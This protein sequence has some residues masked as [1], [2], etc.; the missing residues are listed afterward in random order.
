MRWFYVYIYFCDDDDGDISRALSAFHGTADA[1]KIKHHGR[2]R[3]RCCFSY[4]RS[5]P[6]P[7]TKGQPRL[8]ICPYL[9]LRRCS[10][11]PCLGVECRD[12]RHARITQTVHGFRSVWQAPVN[13]STI[14]LFRENSSDWTINY[15][16]VQAHVYLPNISFSQSLLI[17]ISRSLSLSLRIEHVPKLRSNFSLSLCR[18]K[19][20]EC[21]YDIDLPL[22]FF[23]TIKHFEIPHSYMK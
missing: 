14:H 3:H 16:R 11:S 9:H 2:R 21:L 15:R 10:K 17:S 23:G 4:Y 19:I 13:G 18:S 8:S 22:Q 5:C 20:C 6:P 1:S 12:Q 7:L